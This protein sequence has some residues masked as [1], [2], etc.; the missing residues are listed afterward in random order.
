LDLS[1]HSPAIGSHPGLYVAQPAKLFDTRYDVLWQTARGNYPFTCSVVRSAARAAFNSKR[2]LT[3]E[4]CSRDD[5]DMLL[6][7]AAFRENTG[8]L[9]DLVARTPEI[10]PAV[11][12]AAIDWFSAEDAKALKRRSTHIK[13]MASIQL[14]DT[15][16]SLG[17]TPEDYTFG[18]VASALSPNVV[19]DSL[20]PAHWY[21][22]PG[23]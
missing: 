14:A 19:L 10:L 4:I 22:M 16:S 18:F 21:L 12:T 13:A 8:L 5:P 17:F 15:L 1:E 9:V 6:G 20:A 3:L 11:L 7:Y 23:D 2:Y